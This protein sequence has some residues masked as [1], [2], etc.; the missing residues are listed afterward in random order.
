[1]LLLVSLKL[2]TPLDYPLGN[3]SGW[4]R[5]SVMLPET[6]LPH[7]LA[8]C[9]DR[10]LSAR[11][12]SKDTDGFVVREVRWRRTEEI[13]LRDLGGDCSFSCVDHHLGHCPRNRILVKL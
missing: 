1:M 2:I 5:K 6:T 12:A 3:E 7:G 8:N 4:F 13:L 11:K 10:G 9:E